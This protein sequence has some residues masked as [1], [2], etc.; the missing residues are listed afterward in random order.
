[1]GD[2]LIFAIEVTA[3]SQPECEVMAFRQTLETW[4]HESV[5]GTR[6]KGTGWLAG[7]PV[8]NKLLPNPS[9]QEKDFVGPSMDTGFRL[10]KTATCRRFVL[11]VELAWWLL[12]HKSG[13]RSHS[14]LNFH[15]CENHKGLAEETGYPFIWIAV[16]TSPYQ[17]LEDRLLGR[18]GAKAPDSLRLLSEAFILEFGVPRRLPFIW[19]EERHDEGF[20]EELSR[21]IDILRPILLIDQDAGPETSPERQE[22]EAK[23]LLR[24]L[25]APHPNS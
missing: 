10:G 19:T 17:A 24:E 5:K 1:L 18:S 23:S 8:A 16:Q 6:L 2:E 11:S 12:T 3:A 4:N 7:F 20:A 22:A 13:K 9:S 25:P 14:P 21:A 15:G